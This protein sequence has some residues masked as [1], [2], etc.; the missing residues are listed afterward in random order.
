[1]Q[2][3]S[4]SASLL[5]SALPATRDLFS[6]LLYFTTTTDVPMYKAIVDMLPRFKTSFALPR[7]DDAVRA[8]G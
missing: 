3:S 8:V 2:V 1:M 5:Q 7:Y 6:L 4:Y